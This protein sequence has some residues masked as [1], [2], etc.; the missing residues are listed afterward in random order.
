VKK[1]GER[2]GKKKKSQREWGKKP[3]T[4]KTE[5]PTRFLLPNLREPGCLSKRFGNA[6]NN[7]TALEGGQEKE[8]KARGGGGGGKR[9]RING[10]IIF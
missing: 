6:G 7:V 1:G 3:K 5:D 10:E 8:K 2:K 9:I 4:R